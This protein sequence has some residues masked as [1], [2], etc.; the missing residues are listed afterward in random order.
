MMNGNG[1]AARL[2]RLAIVLAA[3]LV[4]VWFVLRVRGVLTSF[5][6]AFAIAY[7]LNPGV[8]ALERL[9]S[10]ILG[11]VRVLSARGMAVATLSIAV[12]LAI[13]AVAVFVVPTVY[14]QVAETAAKLPG[15]VDAARARVG[16]ALHRLNL[17][18]PAAYEEIRRR[19]EE[20][21]RNHL[22][23]VVAPITHVIGAAFSSV[24]AFV[25]AVLNLVLV[26]VFAI[27]AVRHESH[28]G[29]AGRSGAASLP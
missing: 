29:R 20:T 26:P 2:G 6:L 25:L 1:K 7:V 5:A 9:Y 11:R 24:L 28:H 10:R 27:P 18:Y 23:E 17:R 4:A 3:A 22:P 12:V 13:A 19:V 14:E 21:V 15:Y 16:P 8:N